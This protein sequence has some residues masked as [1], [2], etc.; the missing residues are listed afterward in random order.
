MIS[1]KLIFNKLEEA[2]KMG[3]LKEEIVRSLDL[4]EDSI[5]FKGSMVFVAKNYAK[6]LFRETD[7]LEII[8]IDLNKK[9]VKVL[10]RK[11]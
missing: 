2:V 11:R 8:E 4:H 10:E 7:K 5:G 1:E 6:W 9:T 3:L